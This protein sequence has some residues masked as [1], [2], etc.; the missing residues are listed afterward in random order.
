MEYNTVTEALKQYWG[1]ATWSGIIQRLES[2]KAGES[3][4]VDGADLIV[5]QV[6][7]KARYELAW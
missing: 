5:F 6:P 1:H 4:V 2:D 7:V 3:P